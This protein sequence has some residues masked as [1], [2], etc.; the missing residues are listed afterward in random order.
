MQNLLQ[1]ELVCFIKGVE[2]LAVDVEDGNNL[3]VTDE[4]DDDFTIGG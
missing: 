4:W 2:I 3:V 1:I